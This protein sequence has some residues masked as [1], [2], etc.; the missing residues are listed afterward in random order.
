MEDWIPSP[1]DKQPEALE[2]TE[3]REQRP[4][5]PRRPPID[6][7]KY[8]GQVPTGEGEIESQP[9]KP[10]QKSTDIHDND[11]RAE[12]SGEIELNGEQGEKTGLNDTASSKHEQHIYE[13]GDLQRAIQDKA[14][15]MYQ[16]TE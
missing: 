7:Q 4:K 3:T 11:Q 10:S 6:S 16:I 1:K 14:A 8:T 5:S 9:P 15:A 13:E 12:Q 2:T